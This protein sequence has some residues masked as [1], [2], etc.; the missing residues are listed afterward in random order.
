MPSPPGPSEPGTSTE[1]MTNEELEQIK[2]RLFNAM[3]HEL[4]TPLASLRL[5]AGLLTSAP[6]DGATDAHHQLFQLILHSSDRLDLLITSLMDYARLEAKNLHLDLQTVD[7]RLILESVADLL[8]P[9]YRAKRQ[10]L[11]LQLPSTPVN[12]RGDSF[13]LKSAAQALLDTACKRCPEHGKL[14]MGCRTQVDGALGWVCDTGPHVPEEARA[15]IFTQAY[16][17]TMEDSPS[18]TAFG[19]GL[20]LAHGLMTLHGGSL[21][22]AEP[23]AQEE[24]ICFHFNLPLA[25]V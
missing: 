1:Q 3:A 4:R 23:E 7:L 18:L 9:H 24:G 12:V 6:P 16:W 14:S 11:D 15:D 20:P 25:S 17:Q 8:E 2:T 22:L 5:A 21:W 19:L 13:R 10:M